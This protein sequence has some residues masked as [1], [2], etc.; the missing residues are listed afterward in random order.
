MSFLSVIL[1]WLRLAFGGATTASTIAKYIGLAL[2]A[3]LAFLVAKGASLD[4]SVGVTVGGESRKLLN[5]NGDLAH[6]LISGLAVIAAWLFIAF[7]IA[8]ASTPDLKIIGVQPL[9]ASADR[10]RIVL[11][12]R[13]SRTIR[14]SAN[15]EFIDP[16]IVHH[17]PASL[18]VTGSQPPFTEKDIGGGKTE[19]VDVFLFS[20]DGPQLLFANVGELMAR[21]EPIARREYRLCICVFPTA[22][23]SGSP[24]TRYFRIIPRGD[25]RDELEIIPPGAVKTTA[26]AMAWLL[27]GFFLMPSVLP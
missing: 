6:A 16:G 8:W 21:P 7:G 1:Q 17:I 24:D 10:Q 26:V 12:N 15:L 2:G 20:K 9:A 4:L 25:G 5:A 18:Q 3:A 19:N 27:G 23:N 13:S 22:S 11:H 14:F